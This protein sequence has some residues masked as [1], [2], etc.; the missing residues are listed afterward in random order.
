MET[1]ILE[2]VE[3]KKI[4][5]IIFEQKKNVFL[6]G[7]GGTGKSQVLLCIKR[8]SELKNIKCETTS[9]T[10]ISAFNIRGQTIH[11]F[12]GIGI[13]TAGLDI[14]KKKIAKNVECVKR[15]KNCQLLILDEIS[16]LG[17]K[18]F[19]LIDKVFKHFRRSRLP[20]GGIQVIYTGD[21]LQ[22]PPV[23][24]EFC[25]ESNLWEELDF[26]V[27]KMKRP[28]RYLNMKNPKIGL[29]HF[30][31][32]KRVRLGKHNKE[33]V[34]ILKKREEAY[35]EYQKVINNPIKCIQEYSKTNK[36][37][38]KIIEKY[39]DFETIV[40][41]TMLFS[42]KVDTNMFNKNELDKIKEKEYIF[43]AKDSATDTEYE[44]E[45]DI[46]DMKYYKENMDTFIPSK[47]ILKEKAQ[48]ILVKNIDVDIG[49][50]NGARGIILEIKMNEDNNPIVRVLFKHGITENIPICEFTDE[51]N[52][53]KYT[54]KQI[55]LILGF[56]TTIHKSQGMTLDYAIMDLGPSLFQEALGYV[57]LSRVRELDGILI[58]K[59]IASKIKANKRGLEFED[60][61]D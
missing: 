44:Q 51:F 45:L 11:R 42:T 30:E 8:D 5:K 55:P 31:L 52:K 34:K 60:S 61:I 35:H 1:K 10:G 14:I 48:V 29:K 16:M 38:C 6:C 43:N 39:V 24:D 53:V 13:G 25:F 40:K 27:I 3:Y 26:E 41:P 33:D 58:S 59:L 19:E 46:E 56:A 15:I 54:R 2:P 12:S 32:L 37:I 18:T 22:L 50:S 20:F 23:A 36:N 9:T 4:K 17:L 49:L 7:I 21:F 57:A 47:I 28:Y